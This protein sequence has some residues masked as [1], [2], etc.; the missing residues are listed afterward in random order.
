MEPVSIDIIPL[1]RGDL[2]GRAEHKPRN[3]FF[4]IGSSMGYVLLFE[5]CHETALV[6]LLDPCLRALLIM[7]G[8]DL[9][10]VLYN[11]FLHDH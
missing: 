3:G 6:L 9:F 5:P 7:C 1:P 4:F 11:V 10:Q 2:G 8:A